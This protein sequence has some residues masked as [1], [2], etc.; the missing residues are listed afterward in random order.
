MI[1][2]IALN[3]LNDTVACFHVG[4]LMLVVE[5][6][7]LLSLGVWNYSTPNC[8]EILLALPN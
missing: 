1:A 8:S 4:V 3:A 6:L 5:L 2:L 7:L